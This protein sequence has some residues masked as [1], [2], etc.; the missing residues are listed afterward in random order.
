MLYESAC[1]ARLASSFPEQFFKWSKRADPVRPLDHHPPEHGGEMHP[2]KGGAAEHQQ[3]SQYGK[4]DESE[5]EQEDS[6]GGYAV[7]HGLLFIIRCS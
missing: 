5:M 6:V 3:T 1:I 2:E 4:K 7:D